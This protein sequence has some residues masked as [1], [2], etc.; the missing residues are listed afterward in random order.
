MRPLAFVVAIVAVVV[1]GVR[2]ARA[3][4]WVLP[5]HTGAVTFVVPAIMAAYWRRATAKGI[6]AAMLS[7]VGLN[8][9]LYATGLAV[10]HEFKPYSLLNLDPIIWGLGVSLIVGVWVSLATAPPDAELV[11]R[12]F[13]APVHPQ[14]PT[15]EGVPIAAQPAM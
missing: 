6:I 10:Y 8:L 12:L 9:V 3:Q 15:G 5:E 14:E 13:D 4:A 2:P 7:G 1:A 11:S